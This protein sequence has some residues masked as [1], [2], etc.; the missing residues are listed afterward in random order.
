MEPFFRLKQHN[1]KYHT[2]ENPTCRICGKGFENKALLRNHSKNCLKKSNKL[3]YENKENHVP[4]GDPLPESN[5]PGSNI[6]ESNLAHL[7][8]H[9]ELIP[10]IP[11]SSVGPETLE[12][13]DYVQVLQFDEF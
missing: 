1:E 13:H 6:P 11:L 4:E 12:E 5:L 7:D 10:V 8:T 2:P 3:K 9:V